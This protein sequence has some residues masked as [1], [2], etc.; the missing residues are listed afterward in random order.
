MGPYMASDLLKFVCTFE[1]VRGNSR[2]N[3][4]QYLQISFPKSFPQYLVH[5]GGWDLDLVNEVP[6]GPV[7]QVG[8]E[9]IHQLA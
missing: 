2:Q 3:L 1:T 8:R 7:P 9:R 6:Q 4:S 5:L